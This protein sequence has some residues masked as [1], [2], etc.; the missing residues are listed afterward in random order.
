MK[1][2]MPGDEKANWTFVVDFEGGT[3]VGQYADCTMKPPSRAITATIPRGWG[4]SLWL[5]T[6]ATTRR[7]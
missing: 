3:Y 1:S 5:S 7:R 2:A 4:W 6:R